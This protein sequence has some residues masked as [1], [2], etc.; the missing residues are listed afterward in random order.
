MLVD[1][2]VPVEVLVLV[3]VPVPVEV[4]VL[5]EVEVFTNI[6]DLQTTVKILSTDPTT[7][8]TGIFLSIIIRS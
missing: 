1:V 5:V 4:L 7:F 2:P 8:I 6:H 3:D